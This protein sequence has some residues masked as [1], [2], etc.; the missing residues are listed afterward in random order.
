MIDHLF[1]FFLRILWRSYNMSLH[2]IDELASLFDN[3]LMVRPLEFLFSS[4]VSGSIQELVKILPH[5]F[6]DKIIPKVIGN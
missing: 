4:K 2:M 1:I 5:V 3:I 6:E